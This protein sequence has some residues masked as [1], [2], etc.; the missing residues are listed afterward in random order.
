MAQVS[1]KKAPKRK[2][3][4]STTKVVFR[5]KIPRHESVTPALFDTYEVKNLSDDRTKK[6][7]VKFGARLVQ[8]LWLYSPYG[9]SRSESK[10]TLYIKFRS[11]NEMDTAI[12]DFGQIISKFADDGFA[13]VQEEVETTLGLNDETNLVIVGGSSNFGT[14]TEKVF[15]PGKFTKYYRKNYDAPIQDTNFKALVDKT[16]NSFWLVTVEVDTMDIT[17][18]PHDNSVLI[19]P[20]CNVAD[21]TWIFKGQETDTVNEAAEEA[22]EEY[23]KRLNGF[24]T[25]FETQQKQEEVAVEQKEAEEK[26]YETEDSEHPE[27]VLPTSTTT[28][29]SGIKSLRV[30]IPPNPHSLP[31]TPVKKPSSKTPPKKKAKRG[32]PAKKS[33]L[34]DTEAEEE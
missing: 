24:I 7:R 9:L 29:P 6:V 5:Q 19:T 16:G 31:I 22:K 23:K 14:V 8:H 25:L 30:E 33:L 12:N 3:P 27:S 28:S 1:A 15:F 21:L 17:Y 18:N 2:A 26:T 10:G 4:E 11:S 32:R 13:F 34:V 20:F